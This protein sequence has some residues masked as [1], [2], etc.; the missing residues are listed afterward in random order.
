MCRFLR[1]ALVFLVQRGNQK[2]SE[3]TLATGSLSKYSPE[4]FRTAGG[5]AT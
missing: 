4:W 5:D 2:K 3:V 1:G